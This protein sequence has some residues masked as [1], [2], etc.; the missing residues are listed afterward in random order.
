MMVAGDG[1]LAPEPGTD[2]G[3]GELTAD[4]ERTREQLGET[5]SALGDK[6]DVKGRAQ[7]SAADAKTAV[8]QR[9]HRI[10][11]QLDSH[12]VLCG[13]AAVGLLA[14]VGVLAWMRRR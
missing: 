14:A 12:R 10:G 7:R 2:A 13:S 11:R 8:V 6:F 5:V 1:S 4:I 3:V 9:T